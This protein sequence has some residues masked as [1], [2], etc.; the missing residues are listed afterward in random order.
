[1]PCPIC[2]HAQFFEETYLLDLLD[3]FSDGEMQ[4]AYEKSFGLCLVHVDRAIELFPDH[5]NLPLLLEEQR[6]RIESLRGELA[7]Y[8]RKL[9]YRFSHEPKGAEVTAWRRAVEMMVG[10][11]PPGGR[12]R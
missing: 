2:N 7:E 1:M 11:P 9:D 10:Q 6:K 8:L 3:Y 4:G 12:K 5:E